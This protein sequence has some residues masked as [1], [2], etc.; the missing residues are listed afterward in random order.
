[1]TTRITIERPKYWNMVRS[2]HMWTDEQMLN[3]IVKLG[4]EQLKNITMQS[5]EHDLVESE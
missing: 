5:I 2:Y 3:E 1:M 4:W